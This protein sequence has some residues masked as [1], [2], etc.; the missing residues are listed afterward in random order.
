MSKRF[1]SGFKLLNVKTF[2]WNGVSAD[3]Y[4]PIKVAQV[5]KHQLAIHDMG[6]VGMFMPLSCNS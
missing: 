2:H 6:N 3:L 4:S 1:F 5:C